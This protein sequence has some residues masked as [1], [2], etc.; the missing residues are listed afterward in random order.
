MVNETVLGR[1]PDAPQIV[2][3]S[4]NDAFREKCE[5][6]GRDA[7]DPWLDG[8]VNYEWAHVR[9]A[10]SSLFAQQARPTVFEF[11]CNVGATAVVLAKMG[12]A[13]TA[14]D[15]DSQF[16]DIARLNA[17]RYGV[18]SAVKFASIIDSTELP[19]ANESFDHLV[20]NSVLE[21]VSPE[22][23][24]AV[25][26]ELGRI[27]R[28]GGTVLI[29]GTS[30]RLWP[31]EVHSRRWFSNYVPRV[32]DRWLGERQR[33][34]FPWQLTGGFGGMQNADLEDHCRHYLW[35][36][37]MMGTGRWKIMLL[38]ALAKV[39]RI[40]GVTPG[41]VSPSIAVSLRKPEV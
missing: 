24:M 3:Q 22:L 8:Y 15:I 29:T 7:D 14:V 33:G 30:N 23:L 32:F 37:Q 38:G 20:C 5:E 25:E 34:V 9:F 10:A 13:V 17:Q 39:G 35:A 40:A 31:R 11:G 1:Q 2:S 4:A 28:P 12:A 18:D 16:V 6:L 21:Y 41:L 19:F 36:K 27:L 26:R